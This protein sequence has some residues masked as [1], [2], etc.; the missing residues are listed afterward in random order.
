MRAQKGA[1]PIPD[2]DLTITEFRAKHSAV[3][4]DVAHAEDGG[5][6]DKGKGGAMERSMRITQGVREELERG[7]RWYEEGLAGDGLEGETV[8]EARRL[9]RDGEWWPAKVRKANRFFGRNDRYRDEMES[10]SAP[11]PQR[12]SWALWGG[13]PGRSQVQQLV[14]ALDKEEPGESA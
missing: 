3:I 2:G 12:V 14:T 9:L 5:E 1:G 13:T 10:G 6:K 7:I 8:A 4:A 11:D